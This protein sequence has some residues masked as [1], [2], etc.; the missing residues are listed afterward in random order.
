MI[1]ERNIHPFES[2]T[3]SSQLVK[4]KLIMVLL[5]IAIVAAWFIA[6]LGVIGAVGCVAIIVLLVYGYFI[7]IIFPGS[8]DEKR[9]VLAE[10]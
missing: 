5:I 7:F 1:M 10:N 2:F 6:Q 3:G 9:Y 8:C 4:P